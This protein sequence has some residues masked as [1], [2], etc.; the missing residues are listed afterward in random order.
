MARI[1]TAA[2]LLA[3]GAAGAAR[4]EEWATTAVSST[5]LYEADVSTLEV[6][7]DVVKSWMRETLVRPRR[8]EKTH[9]LFVVTL[10]QRSDDCGGRRFALGA[11][12]RRDASG[13]TAAS[14]ESGTG[15]QAVAPGSVAE[16]IWRTVCT[17]ARPPKEKAFLPSIADG[18]WR[19]LGQSAD[20]KYLL[21]VKSDEIVKLGDNLVGSIARSDY[22]QPEWIDGYAV[23]HIVAL[24]IV[25][26]A[27]E[28]SASA[29]AD[30]YASPSLRVRAARVDPK[31][32]KFEPMAPGS[33]L[34]NNLKELCA[35]AR[36]LKAKAPEA[37][38]DKEPQFSSGTAWGVDKGYLVTAAHVI[39]GANAIDV[40]RDGEKVGEAKVVVADFANDLALLSF[41]KAPPGKL[42]VLPLANRAPVL[43]RP[44][45]T[46]GYPAPE[47]MGQ[48]VKMTSG[49]IN[50]ISGMQDDTRMLQISIPVQGGNSGGPVMG[51]D[52]SVLGVVDSKLEKL[53]P[54][55]HEPP[56]NVNYAVK[57][58][59]LKP[60]LD[61]LPDLG[62]YEPVKAAATQEETIAAVRE[63]VFMLLVAH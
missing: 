42:K 57:S 26:C 52:A 59:Y 43:G 13:Q 19:S 49:Q 62:N 55:G 11:Y 15:W 22:A 9:K 1:W 31:Q 36:P 12:V 28:T 56:Q 58:A 8:D 5:A 35:A 33:F 25:D 63:A 23:R 61:D 45:F 38:K 29:G 4:A 16:S 46:L 44:V 53:D 10:T 48:A 37:D 27:N 47:V 40:Y 6:K 41:T 54:E 20:R 39:D 24:S 60:M 50:S 3:A 14:G 17:A 51:W 18:A 30:F 2:L 34:A 32:A 21:S 7:Q